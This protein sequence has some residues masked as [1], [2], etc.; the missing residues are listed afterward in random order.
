MALPPTPDRL[1]PKMTTAMEVAVLSRCLP[2]QQAAA[3]IEQ[4]ARS[5][6][7]GARI[8]AGIEMR[9]RILVGIE[10]A[11]EAAP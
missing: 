11:P 7:A 4:Y 5:E 3:L 8:E 9:D 6:A 1:K 2:I 10:G